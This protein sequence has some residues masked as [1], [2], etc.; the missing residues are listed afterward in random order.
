M[1]EFDILDDDLNNDKLHSFI[2]SRQLVND[3]YSRWHGATS[4]QPCVEI[5]L[6]LNIFDKY[7]S[8]YLFTK[9]LRIFIYL[10]I[11]KRSNNI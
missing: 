8:I 2:V 7:L 3:Y 5:Y 1:K 9:I 4:N 10:F 6:S 11:S